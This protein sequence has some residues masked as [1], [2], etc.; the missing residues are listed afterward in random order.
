MPKVA[1]A[2]LFITTVLVAVAI[3]KAETQSSESTESVSADFEGKI[4]L[5]QN[6]IIMTSEGHHRLDALTDAKLVQLGGRYFVRGKIWNSS[7]LPDREYQEG[8]DQAIAWDDIAGFT[9]LT[10]EQM[11]EYDSNGEAE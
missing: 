7:R 3:S 5:L 2:L 1:Y 4:V 10:N 11:K 6:A 8:W 9:V